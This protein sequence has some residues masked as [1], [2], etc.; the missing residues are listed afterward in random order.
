[1]AKLVLV[2]SVVVLLCVV[3]GC[4]SPSRTNPPGETASSPGLDKPLSR[5]KTFGGIAFGEPVAVSRDFGGNLL[6]A[7]RTPGQIVHLLLATDQAVEF[8]RPTSGPGFAPVDL[9][10]T[11]FFVYVVDP[12][13]RAVLRFYKTGSYLGVLIDLED[14]FPGRRVTPMGMD[15]DG[16]GRIVLTDVKN[17]AVIIFNTYLDVEL[18]FGS[19]G[20]FEGQLDS[21]E[22]VFFANGGLIL[23]TDS[24]NRRLQLF[25]PDGGY[26][27]TVPEG[28][29]PNPLRRPRHAVMDKAG[30]IYVADPE[31]GRVFL[32]DEAGVL[33]RTI[34]PDGA[35][36]F[37]PTDVAVAPT[38]TIYVTDEATS[39]LYVFR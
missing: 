38:G 33:S 19:Y 20:R 21:P 12:V 2:L 13:Q 24:G 8:D 17:H 11:G 31:A 23:V 34:A 27:R 39:S 14:R 1:M 18:Q 30:W 9:K 16:S 5:Y 32:F 7:D 29:N 25:D 28:G 10:Q 36:R 26:V 4:G 37:R 3:V 15:V 35:A 6:V 22:G